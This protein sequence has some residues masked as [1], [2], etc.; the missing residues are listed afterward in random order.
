MIEPTRDYYSRDIEEPRVERFMDI[1]G[2]T[3]VVESN[4]GD[5]KPA[6]KWQ[7]VLEM[8]KVG[9]GRPSHWYTKTTKQRSNWFETLRRPPSTTGRQRS[10]RPALPHRNVDSLQVPYD[11]Q[12]QPIYEASSGRSETET[13]LP[14]LD[15]GFTTLVG[16]EDDML[17]LAVEGV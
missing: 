3:L 14:E 13:G 10:Q 6:T 12:I 15:D 11:S 8:P 9:L 1:K 2:V 4:D 5:F 7:E 17:P 16:A